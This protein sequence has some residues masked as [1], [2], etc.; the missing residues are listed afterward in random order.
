MRKW[1]HGFHRR[2]RERESR[3]LRLQQA[4]EPGRGGEGRVVGGREPIPAARRPHSESRRRGEGFRRAGR[5]RAGGC[6]GGAREGDARSSSR[7]S[8][9]NDPEAFAKFQ[10]AQGE[11][12]SALKSL[13]AT[14]ETYPDLKSDANFRDLQVQLEGTENRITVARNRYIEAVQAYNVTVREF[15]TQSHR[16]HVRLRGEAQF[17]GGERGGDLHGARP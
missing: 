10:A 1:C 17:H 4:A 2:A 5:A 14:V 3:R 8:C 7:P 16:E 13:L 9:I 6:D 15:P 11:L 12:T